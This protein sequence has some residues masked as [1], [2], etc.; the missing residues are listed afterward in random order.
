[1]YSRPSVRISKA[2]ILDWLVWLEDDVVG[3]FTL[4]ADAL[5]YA[6]ILECSP[7]ARGN[8]SRV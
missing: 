2:G 5:D 6:T 7:R 3:R 1:M 4:V 8:A